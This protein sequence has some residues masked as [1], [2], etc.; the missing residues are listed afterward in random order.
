MSLID[1]DKDNE[2]KEAVID[3][4]TISKLISIRR[5]TEKDATCAAFAIEFTIQELMVPS[6]SKLRSKLIR[7]QRVV[8]WPKKETK[9]EGEKEEEVKERQI[10]R[11]MIFKLLHDPIRGTTEETK[12]ERFG[13]RDGRFAVEPEQDTSSGER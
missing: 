8:N 4:S 3:Q 13:I 10:D 9:K 7:V 11:S 5:G 1:N 6:F 12:R 2:R